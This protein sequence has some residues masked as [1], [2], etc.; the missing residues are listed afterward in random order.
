MRC[1]YAYNT[2]GLDAIVWKFDRMHAH[3]YLVVRDYAHDEFSLM[4][5]RC[6]IHRSINEI[7]VM[8]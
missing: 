6:E 7:R 2:R 8:I 1:N 5:L 4:R 3:A